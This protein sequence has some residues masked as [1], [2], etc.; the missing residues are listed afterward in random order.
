MEILL[1]GEGYDRVRLTSIAELLPHGFE[2]R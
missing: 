2:L 1:H